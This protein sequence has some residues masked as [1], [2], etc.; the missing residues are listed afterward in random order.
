M[1]LKTFKHL[2]VPCEQ[3]VS[4]IL[5][6]LYVYWRTMI[7]CRFNMIVNSLRREAFLLSVEVKYERKCCVNAVDLTLDELLACLAKGALMIFGI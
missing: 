3:P 4:L 7:S 5:S 1:P 6:V 2:Q